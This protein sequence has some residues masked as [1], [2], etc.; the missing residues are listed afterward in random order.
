VKEHPL[1]LDAESVVA[2]ET[3]V[4]RESIAPPTRAVVRALQYTLVQLQLQHA[5]EPADAQAAVR[6]SE[7]SVSTLDA[8]LSL[9]QALRRLALAANRD[10]REALQRS[11]D[12]F[13]REHS[14]PER[15]RLEAWSNVPSALGAVD[16]ASLDHRLTG[17]DPNAVASAA[18]DFLAQ[19]QDA[20]DDVIAFLLRQNG[21][22]SRAEKLSS[23]SWHDLLHL[24]QGVAGAGLSD[25]ATL[26]EASERWMEAWSWPSLHEGNRGRVQRVL[27]SPLEPGNSVAVLE[28]SEGKARLQL[29]MGKSWDAGSELLVAVSDL[30]RLLHTSTEDPVEARRLLTPSVIEMYRSFFRRQ[31]E[32]AH[33]LKRFAQVQRE[34]VNDVARASAAMELLQLRAQAGH[35]LF[36]RFLDAHGP[37]RESEQVFG[38]R[39]GRAM[40]VRPPPGF[41]LRGVEALSAPAHRLEGALLATQLKQFLREQFDE[42]YFRNPKAGVWLARRIARGARETSDSL[43]RALGIGTGTETPAPTSEARFTLAPVAASILKSLEA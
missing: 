5:A 7:P 20:Y 18:E 11:A 39:L 41:F 19:T 17:L 34:R 21:L 36:Q 10:E 43:Q 22:L 6:D 2:L 33:W 16:R 42:E 35:F 32:E 23:A 8:R 29:W 14:Q 40:G 13:L 9:S 37:T 31:R 26:L 25:A 12:Q 15:R 1:L 4:Q 30:Q 3:L 27:Q 38:E 24:C 28:G